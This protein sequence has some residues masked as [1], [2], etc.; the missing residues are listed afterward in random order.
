VRRLRKNS[1]E[2]TSEDII[3][4]YPSSWDI[5]FL[6]IA[7]F[8]TDTTGIRT[9]V[10]TDFFE[11]FKV[12]SDN[13]ARN[14]AACRVFDIFSVRCADV[15]D[16]YGVLNIEKEFI[17]SRQP[18]YGVMYDANMVASMLRK[19]IPQDEKKFGVH[20]IVF[21]DR[22]IGTYTGDRYHAH[23]VHCSVPSIISTLGLV[24]APARPREFYALRNMNP[25]VPEEIL[26]E[27]F[28]DC[29]LTYND[30][31]ITRI[32]KGIALQTVLWAN[33]YYPFC[34]HRTCKLYD[35]HWQEELI[36]SQMSGKL[37]KMHATIIKRIKNQHK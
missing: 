37:C 31:R 17:G 16:S 22:L 4:I 12:D 5:Q 6:E 3:Y 35:A 34:K 23:V 1:F 11:H 25:Y 13:I 10:R 33:G 19:I 8:L 26:L 36:K 14:F 18:V 7:R 9:V 29:V 2:N 20:H 30:P 21:L 32:A 28:K 15:H 27:K 24:Q